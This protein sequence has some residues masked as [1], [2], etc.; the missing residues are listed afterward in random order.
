MTAANGTNAAPDACGG[1]PLPEVQVGELD[2]ALFEAYFSDLVECA[3]VRAVTVKAGPETH[4]EEPRVSLEQ[5]H[6]LLLVGSVRG[7]Q[8]RY[9]FEGVEW[10]DTLVAQGDC[11]R[12]I[13]IAAA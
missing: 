6:M 4:A 8:I 2:G 3:D 7:V 9:L 10:I 1:E 5:A 13:R 12:L 11:V